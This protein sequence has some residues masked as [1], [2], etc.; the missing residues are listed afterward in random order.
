MASVGWSSSSYHKFDSGIVTLF[1]E[2][3]D[4]HDL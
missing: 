1:L 2:M 3:F 4:F